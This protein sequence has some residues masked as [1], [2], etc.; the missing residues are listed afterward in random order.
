MAR[1]WCRYKASLSAYHTKPTDE[2]GILQ[3][4]GIEVPYS[5]V[6]FHLFFY[7]IISC[8]KAL[9]RDS[10]AVQYCLAIISICCNQREA[11]MISM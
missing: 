4:Y 7:V 11:Y 2:V 3:W 10:W 5:A 9:V 1:R 8:K 6:C